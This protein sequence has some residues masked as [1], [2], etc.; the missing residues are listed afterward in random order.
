MGF[1][2]VRLVNKNILTEIVSLNRSLLVLK[3]LTR[4]LVY[5][6]SSNWGL[7]GCLIFSALFFSGVVL[8][9]FVGVLI[10]LTFLALGY[11]A[12][13]FVRVGVLAAALILSFYN[14]TKLAEGDLVSYAV[15]LEML[16]GLMLD[17]LLSFKFITFDMAEPVFLLYA[18]VSTFFGGIG[19][20]VFFST[21]LIYSLL[22][23]SQ[24]SFVSQLAN[25]KYSRVDLVSRQ[26]AILAVCCAAMFSINFVQT[27][28]L[29]KQYLAIAI[30]AISFQ[31]F[32]VGSYLKAFMLA[33]IGVLTHN[34]LIVILLGYVFVLFVER[35]VRHCVGMVFLVALLFVVGEGVRDLFSEYLLVVAKIDDGSIPHVLYVLD[36]MLL[37]VAMIFSRYS[38]EREQEKLKRIFLVLALYV[39]VLFVVR[40]I[41]LLMLRMYFTLD[42]FR[43]YLSSFLIY[44][45][46][47]TFRL[48]VFGRSV[49]SVVLICI[50]FLYLSF[51][52]SNTNWV[53]GESGRNSFLFGL[54]ELLSI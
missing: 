54:E 44:K 5:F 20:F 33:L 38:S 36:V 43:C 51:R 1:G 9:F 26:S 27:A 24:V 17:E 50:F 34:M 29:V 22:L 31:N 21:F 40:D 30:M 7:V 25:S 18:Y 52:L 46:F 8:P 37:L 49:V 14:A 32:L 11:K 10:C 12:A 28:H 23:N 15:L 4:K 48:S 16:S 2:R 47:S 6:L 42:L 41:S 53:Y 39:A 45:V 19:E 35:Y 13:I 3:I